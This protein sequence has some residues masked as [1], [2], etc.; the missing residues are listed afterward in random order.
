M[1]ALRIMG[2]LN[3]TPDS[4]SDGGKYDAPDKALEWALRLQMDGADLIDVGGESTRPGAAEVPL[5]EELERV[6]PVVKRLLQ[7]I[8][9]HQLSVDSRKDVVF[10]RVLTEGVRFFNRVGNPPEASLLQE[11]ATAGGSVAV[12][13]IH[14]TPADMQQAPL[15][16]GEA[17]RA[18]ES[19][20]DTAARKFEKAGLHPGSYWL[21][22]G[23]GFGKTVAAN[24]E[25]LGQIKGWSQRWPL[26]VGVSR[27]GFIGR[28]FGIDQ[29][30]ERDGPGKVIEW[31]CAV[32]GA[33]LIRTHDVRGLAALRD[34]TKT[35]TTG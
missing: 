15:G 17:V 13:H 28:I 10:E 32:S 27:K 24:L 22:P 11:I 3:V 6:M 8:P 31:M 25:L 7:K 35:A 29:P 20:F 9:G 4:F 21:D 2:V 19:F 26:M 1:D 14:G 33:G 34:T 30:V 16:P 12:T 18:V 23:I 5:A